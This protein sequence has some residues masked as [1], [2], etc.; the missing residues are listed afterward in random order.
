VWFSLLCTAG[1]VGDQTRLATF[2]AQLKSASQNPFVA[3]V[4]VQAFFQGKTP[5][6]SITSFLPILPIPIEVTY[7]LIE[8]YPA[9]APRPPSPPPERLVPEIAPPSKTPKK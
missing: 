2:T 4:L 3:L 5:E 1:V 7:A 8:R 9:P 6:R